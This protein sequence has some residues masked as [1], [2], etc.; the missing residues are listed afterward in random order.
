MKTFTRGQQLANITDN[1]LL[2]TNRGEARALLGPRDSASTKVTCVKSGMFLLSSLTTVHLTFF[3]RSLIFTF[4]EFLKVKVVQPRLFTTGSP[5]AEIDSN[6]APGL[7]GKRY[8][9]VVA[10]SL[11]QQSRTEAIVR[12]P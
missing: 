12:K 3:C 6:A 7:K 11:I 9:F 2:Q 10:R 4:S 8:S 5:R 1:S